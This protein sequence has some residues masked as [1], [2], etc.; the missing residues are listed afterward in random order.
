MNRYLAVTTLALTVGGLAT[1]AAVS[2]IDAPAARAT[3]AVAATGSTYFPLTPVRLFDTR[4][5]RTPLGVKT[6]AIAG[7]AG[8]PAD[9]T[10]VVLN[11]TAVD[12]TAA[13][14]LTVYPDGVGRPGTSNLNWTARQAATPNQVTVEVGRDGRVDFYNAHGTV[15]VIADLE[16]YFAGGTLPPTTTTRTTTTP[17]RSTTSTSSATVTTPGPTTTTT[18]G[19]TAVTTTNV[20]GT[21]VT[22]S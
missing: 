19:A 9:A 11:V 5:S 10:A 6:V 16:G 22:S 18:I 20:T 15:D 8:V 7:V 3:D 2:G 1:V 17:P 21:D 4:S 13:S 12:G 14:Y